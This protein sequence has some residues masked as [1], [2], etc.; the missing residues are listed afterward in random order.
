MNPTLEKDPGGAPE[1]HLWVSFI[2]IPVGYL[3][4]G[5]HPS[6]CGDM[7]V[8]LAWIAFFIQTRM[9]W[10]T[11]RPVGTIPLSFVTG[12]LCLVIS[13]IGIVIWNSREFVFWHLQLLGGFGILT[14]AVSSWVLFEN[15]GDFSRLTSRVKPFNW[16]LFILFMAMA[17]RVSADVVLHIRL[18][19]LA[20]ASVMWAIASLVWLWVILPIWRRR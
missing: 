8:L 2:L 10:R 12:I 9:H 16:M 17:T 15:S 4:D 14:F 13:V 3:I 1:C 5:I 18:S 6:P 7:L 20:Y 11:F 19:H